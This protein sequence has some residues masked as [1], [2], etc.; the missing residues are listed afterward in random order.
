MDLPGLTR[1]P[2]KDQPSTLPSTVS[3]FCN[4]FFFS[5]CLYFITVD[6]YVFV[7]LEANPV[8]I[9]ALARAAIEPDNVIIL[10]VSSANSDIANSEAIRLA[11]DVDPQASRT[12]GVLTKCDLLEDPSLL[13]HTLGGR[14]V[15]LPLG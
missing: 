7:L 5:K 11:T 8:Q 14:G 10:A 4:V 13:V 15:R 12:V 2:L 3:T 6:E 1:V 9:Y